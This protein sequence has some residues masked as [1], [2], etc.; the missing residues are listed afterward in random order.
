MIETV[1]TLSV[2]RARILEWKRAGLRIG[3]VPTMGNLHAGHFSLVEALRAR[4]DRV[5][6]SV[7]VNPTQFGPNEDFARYPRTPER[8]AEGL[9]AA[10]CDLLWLPTVEAMYP[11]GLHNAVTVRVP[12]VSE[13]LDG[14]H[15]PGHFDGVATVV[16]RLLNQVQP[17]VAAF[18]R[19]DYQQLAVI[20][21]LVTDLAFPVD[22][23]PVA[24]AREPDGLAM[25]SRNQYLDTASRARAPALY[26]SL[27]ALAQAMRSG[28]P[29]AE[30]ASQAIAALRA[31]GFDVDYVE[32]R[33]PD[34]SPYLAG[35]PVA[36]ALA[37]ARLGGT[38]LI[39]NLEFRLDAAPSAG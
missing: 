20:S 21:H 18:G 32:V 4:V 19:K 24:I 33:A 35:Q 11:L 3:L 25:S 38:R 7:F 10:G 1:D 9:D 12:G 6:A 34:L 31:E 39:D 8:D 17:D 2:L 15:R 37:A 13:I 36:V 5:V 29:A 30:A 28:S 22:L 16:A 27:L 23:L 26:R 14:A